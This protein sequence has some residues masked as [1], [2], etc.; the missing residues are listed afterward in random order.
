[1]QSTLVGRDRELEK[2]TEMTAGLEAGIGGIAALIGEAG[3]GKSR[4]LQE[5]KD[6]YQNGRLHFANGSAY[7]HT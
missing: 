7:S 2:L 4:L 5:S 6:V 3:I 1:L